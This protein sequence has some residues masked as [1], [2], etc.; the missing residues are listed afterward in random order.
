VSDIQKFRDLAQVV[1]DE[2]GTDNCGAALARYAWAIFEASG[3]EPVDGPKNM[4]AMESAVLNVL[5]G[6]DMRKAKKA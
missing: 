1:A 5:K 4:A 3:I 6:Y 2:I